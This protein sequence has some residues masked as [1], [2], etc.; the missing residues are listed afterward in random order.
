ML[1]QVFSSPIPK[2]LVPSMTAHHLPATATVVP[3]PE[4]VFH[5]GVVTPSALPH[6][7][8]I[9]DNALPCQYMG[10]LFGQDY[11]SAITT[12]PT[13]EPDA[14]PPTAIV[15]YAIPE[16]Y[17]FIQMLPVA[18]STPAPNITFSNHPSQFHPR[19]SYFLPIVFQV[20]L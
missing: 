20:A 1:G 2:S 18:V 16:L 10:T 6:C 9:K 19:A 8:T 11:Y 15:P 7:S 5:N 12:S 4:A 13:P 3:S 17:L 14:P